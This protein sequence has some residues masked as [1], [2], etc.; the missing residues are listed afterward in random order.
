MNSSSLAIAATLAFFSASAYAQSC[1]SPIEV[2][3][4]ATQF[5]GNTCN[6]TNQLP[7]LV[8]GAVQAP[9]NQDIYHL[10]V[11]DGSGIQL[12][13]TPAV[14]L[15]GVLFVCRNLCA[16]YS[17]CVAAVDSGGIGAAEMASLPPGPGDYYVIIGSVVPACGTYNLTV[18]AP[19][20]IP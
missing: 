7:Y 18:S 1:A 12:Q 11:T 10:R 6:S 20:G 13:L 16:T 2:S 8:N 5:T 15:D 4:P 17:S 19:L 3:V 14:A 9:G